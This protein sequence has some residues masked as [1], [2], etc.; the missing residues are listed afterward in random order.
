MLKDQQCLIPECQSTLRMAVIELE[1]VEVQTVKA[2]PWAERLAHERLQRKR[3]LSFGSPTL[4][5]VD[6]NV[7]SDVKYKSS[8]S[9]RLLMV[10][11]QKLVCMK[12]CYRTVIGSH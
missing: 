4:R 3:Q 1:I 9:P 6:V 10:E 5:I 2:V 8:A 11:K 7:I 12:I